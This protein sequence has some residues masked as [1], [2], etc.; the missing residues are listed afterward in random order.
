[1]IATAEQKVLLSFS[2]SAGLAVHAFNLIPSK[3]LLGPRL[4]KS[5]EQYYLKWVC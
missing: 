5:A 3:S 2:T 1:M 4:D